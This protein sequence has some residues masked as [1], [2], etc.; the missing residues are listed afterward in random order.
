MSRAGL[1]KALSPNGNPSFATIT[2]LTRALGIQVILR[3]MPS[4]QPHPEE[5]PEPA[6]T[7]T[8][9]PTPSVG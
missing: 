3:P 2:R 5:T 1:Y 9:S 7:E 4:D 8:R 6:E